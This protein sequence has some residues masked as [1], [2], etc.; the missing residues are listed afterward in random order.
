[1]AYALRDATP[2]PQFKLQKIRGELRGTFRTPLSAGCF[3]FGFYP[4]R[5]FSF[6][7]FIFYVPPPLD[8]CPNFC[9][10]CV[11]ARAHKGVDTTLTRAGP[12]SRAEGA[13]RSPTAPSQ[14]APKRLPCPGG[15]RQPLRLLTDKVALASF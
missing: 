6:S 8:K 1:M 9:P 13:Q 4:E 11:C 2:T 15:F 5:I 10:W 12:D 3:F 7:I 14:P